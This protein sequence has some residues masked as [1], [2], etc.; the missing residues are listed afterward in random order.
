MPRVEI[1][2]GKYTDPETACMI[3]EVQRKARHAVL[4][5][6]GSGSTS[7]S[8]SGQTHAGPGGVVDMRT[9]PLTRKQKMDQLIASRQVGFAAWIR[10]YVE[11][12]WGEHEHA[13][14]IGSKYLSSAAEQQVQAYLHGRDGLA[15][16]RKDPHAGLNIAP[17]TVVPIPWYSRD[18]VLRSKICRLAT[19]IPVRSRFSS[20]DRFVSKWNGH[21]TSSFAVDLKNSLIVS[22]ASLDAA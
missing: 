22:V 3:R 7:V 6:Q 11:D 13:V 18:R 19:R 8:A 9:V 14:A 4:I 12:L 10:P 5:A 21:V 16:N 17:T 15:G 2:P 1:A 20:S